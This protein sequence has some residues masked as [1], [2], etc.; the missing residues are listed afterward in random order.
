LVLAAQVHRLL[1]KALM[2]ATPF[3]AASHPQ[4]AVVVAGG[5]ARDKP[6]VQVGLAVAVAT[7]RVLVARAHRAKAMPVVQAQRNRHITAVAEVAGLRRLA[8]TAWRV[9]VAVMAVLALHQASAAPVLLTR[10]AVAGVLST[11]TLLAVA[12]RVAAEPERWATLQRTRPE[13]QTQVVAVVEQVALHFQ[14]RE[15]AVVQE[16]L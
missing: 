2:A 10:V 12:A 9:R 3:S 8:R 14:D 16:L 4:A 13:L 11:A 7:A 5:Q 1:L 15:E 6:A